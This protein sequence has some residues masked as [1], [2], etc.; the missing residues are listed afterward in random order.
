ML[1]RLEA[2]RYLHDEAV[3]VSESYASRCFGSPA[4][5]HTDIELRVDHVRYNSA[6]GD[7]SQSN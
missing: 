7:V 4:L 1:L 6:L 5:W 2:V 3:T